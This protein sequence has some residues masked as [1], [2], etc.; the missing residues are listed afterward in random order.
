MAS[1][2]H[3]FS[4]MHLVW[5]ACFHAYVL[6]ALAELQR[7]EQPTKEDG[8]ISFL[9]VGDW[10]RKGNYNQSNVAFQ[11]FFILFFKPSFKS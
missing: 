1:F 6:C 5:M 9:V 7:F 11:V 8:S 2:S 4:L 3:H 10:G